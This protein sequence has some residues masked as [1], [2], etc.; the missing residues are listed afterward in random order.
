MATISVEQASIATIAPP[1]PS[2]SARLYR[3]AARGRLSEVVYALIDRSAGAIVDTR[4]GGRTPLQAAAWAGHAAVVS[5]LLGAGADVDAREGESEEAASSSGWTALMAASAEGHAEVVQALLEAGAPA[6][7]AFGPERQ[8]PLLAAAE[9]GHTEVLEALLAAGADPSRADAEGNTALYSAAWLGYDDVVECLLAAGAD[10]DAATRDGRTP[11]FAAAADGHVDIVRALLTAGAK[12]DRARTQGETALYIASHK[13]LLDVVSVLLDAG[14][15]AGLVDLEGDTPL[16][17]AAK[18]GHEEVVEALFR[19]GGSTQVAHTHFATT[20]SHE[21]KAVIFRA[22]DSELASLRLQLAEQAAAMEALRAAH[23]EEMNQ[24][25][26]GFPLAL[27]GAAAQMQR[28]RDA[29]EREVTALRNQS[30]RSP[31]ESGAMCSV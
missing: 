29:A 4:V 20:C 13:G 28:E 23:A 27:A 6:D 15:D 8:T 25:I 30:K 24:L 2:P 18:A 16:S 21:Q 5:A 12:V 10:A 22:A 11:L 7:A 14:A 9:E 19:R 26:A 17:L 31:Q 1:Q 3:A